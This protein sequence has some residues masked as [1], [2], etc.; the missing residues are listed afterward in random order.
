MPEELYD[1]ATIKIGASFQELSDQFAMFAKLYPNY[2]IGQDVID[3]LGNTNAVVSA[4]LVRIPFK[5][6][7]SREQNNG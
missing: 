1:V 4:K 7:D 5:I 3:F 6:G 2:R